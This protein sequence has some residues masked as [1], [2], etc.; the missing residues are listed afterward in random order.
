MSAAEVL[1]SSVQS[2]SA[3]QQ[4]GRGFRQLV[5]HSTFQLEVGTIARV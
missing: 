1:N 5:V 2:A 4:T 3:A